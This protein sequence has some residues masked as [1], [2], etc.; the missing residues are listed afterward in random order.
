MT[1]VRQTSGI[2]S[3]LLLAG[4]ACLSGGESGGAFTLFGYTHK[5]PFDFDIRTVYVPIAQNTTYMRGIEFDLT[6][7]VVNQLGTSPYKVTS[8]R[9]RADTELIMKIVANTKSVVLR[10]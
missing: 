4:L 5:P 2:A 3:C 6:N 8:D 9:T 7:A 10:S 1:T